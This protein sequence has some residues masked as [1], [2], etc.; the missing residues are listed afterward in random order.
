MPKPGLENTKGPFHTV[1]CFDVA[2]IVFLLLFRKRSKD[3]GHQPGPQRISTVSQ[4]PASIRQLLHN[5][6]YAGVGKNVSIMGRTSILADNIGESVVR[7]NWGMLIWSCK[8]MYQHW[9]SLRLT[10]ILIMLNILS[11]LLTL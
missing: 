7:R 5:I 1:S 8:F 9:V 6:W 2:C 4:E 11:W 3:R 10:G